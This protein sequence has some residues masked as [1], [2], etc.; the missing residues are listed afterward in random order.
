MAR[1]G[2][3]ACGEKSTQKFC[4]SIR[5]YKRILEAAQRLRFFAEIRESSFKS[6]DLRGAA[7]LLRRI[8]ALGGIL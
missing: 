5:F 1:M 6:A 4:F 8:P 2:G 7:V 3:S